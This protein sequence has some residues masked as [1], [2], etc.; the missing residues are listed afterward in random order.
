MTISRTRLALL[1]MAVSFFVSSCGGS[2]SSGSDPALE[3]PLPTTGTVALLFTDRPT[4]EFSAIKLNVL[5]AILIGG[6][7][8]DGQQQLFEGVEPIDLL[9]L[10]NFNEPIIFGEVD[11]GIYTKLRLIIDDLELV[12]SDGGPSQFPALPANGKID[13]LD[14]NGIEVLPG[15]TLIV[16]IDMEANKAL[17]ITGAGNSGRYQFRP[18]VKVNFMD[19]DAGVLPDKLARLEGTASNIDPAGTFTLCDIETPNSCVDVATNA[20]T[21]IFGNEGAPADFTALGDMAAVVVIGNYTVEGSIVL[22]AVILEIGGNAEQI[23]G[24]VVSDPMDDKFLLLKDD[25]TDIV[26][27]LQ[28]GT[29][30]Y[31]ENGMLGPDAV[32]LGTDVEVEG[33]Q[34][35]KAVDTDPDLIRAALVFIMAEE[36]EQVSGTIIEP[37][38]PATSSFGLTLADGSGDICVRVDTDPA[39]DVLLVDVTASEVTMAAFTNLYVGQVVDLFGVMND[40]FDAN[41]V[42][43]DVNASPPPP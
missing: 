23:K 37:L 22:N 20:G 29:M 32:V 5:E 11:A 21:S 13:L 14:P 41:E 10:T 2:G 15:R 26:V 7:S 43:V 33:V 27:E 1:A 31:D 35:P 42:I 38:D 30:Y 9:D 25:D 40:C 34:P 6:D 3:E 28:V 16:E 4:D 19:G 24:Q 39:A 17:K 18:V 12:P 8:V 36:D